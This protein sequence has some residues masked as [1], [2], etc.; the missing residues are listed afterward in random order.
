MLND[1]LSLLVKLLRDGALPKLRETLGTVASGGE[2]PYSTAISELVKQQTL[3]QD[4]DLEKILTLVLA[5]L[6]ADTAE[7]KDAQRCGDCP[8][9]AGQAGEQPLAL[10]AR[11]P[12]E[13]DIDRAPLTRP[14]AAALPDAAAAAEDDLQARIRALSAG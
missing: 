6:G 3:I 10:P 9:A 14:W 7:K 13:F 4:A 12:M 11:T 5:L 1:I 8:Y 2:L